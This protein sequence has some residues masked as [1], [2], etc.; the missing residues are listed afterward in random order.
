MST[1]IMSLIHQV[2]AKTYY[3]SP[4]GNDANSGVSTSDPWETVSKVNFTSFQPGDRVLFERGGEWREQLKASSSGTPGKPIIYDAYGHGPKP[5]FWGS[6]VLE[7]SKWE[8]EG[9][10]VYAFH[11]LGSKV[12]AVLADHGVGPHGQ[13]YTNFSDKPLKDLP[14]NFRWQGGVLRINSASDPRTD[15]RLYTAAVRQDI[16]YS[17]A[18]D[19]LVF[20]NLIGDE[21]CEPDGGYVFRVM[22]S[23]DVLIE[24]CEAYRGGRHHFGIINSTGFVGRRL[25]A[26]YAMPHNIAL[27]SSLFVSYAGE[28][29]KF[30]G[31]SSVWEDCI[32]EHNEDGE[33]GVY[34]YF[35][36]HGEKTGLIRL[37]RPI[38][39]GSLFTIHQENPNQR[40]EVTGGLVQDADYEL[41]CDNSITDGLTLV[42]ASSVAVQGSNNLLQNI[43][44]KHIVPLGDANI[45]EKGAVYIRKGSLSNI[46]RSSTISLDDNTPKSAPCL[47]L[48]GDGSHTRLQGNVLLSNGP[49]ILAVGRGLNQSDLEQSDHNPHD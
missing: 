26:A 32:G 13:W 6:D 21:T 8:A 5:R 1:I 42:G 19:H 7:N 36:C 43:K 38:D 2:E 18:K 34:M 20:R 10:N 46:I 47:V 12:T 49:K 45:E 11:G 37:I 14:N 31:C 23:S 3:V 48:E 29:A 22:D 41:I 40:V 24:D 4:A 35:V 17:N 30:D 27:S 33:G 28:N 39:R 9:G 25:K 15:G 44:M 16:I